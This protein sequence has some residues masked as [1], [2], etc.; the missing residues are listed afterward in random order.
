MLP[1]LCGLSLRF[2]LPLIAMV[3]D[4][5][6]VF[7]SIGLQTADRDVTRFLWLKDPTCANLD[8]NT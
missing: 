6:K 8:N 5:G 4:I 1:D 3:W 7:L 2:Q